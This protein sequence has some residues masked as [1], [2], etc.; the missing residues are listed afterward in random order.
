MKSRLKQGQIKWRYWIQKPSNVGYF[1]L[2][3]TIVILLAISLFPLIYAI[4]VSL[5][6]YIISK[7]YLGKP[8]VGLGNYVRLFTDKD[9]YYSLRVTFL[10]ALPAIAGEYFLGLCCALLLNR[11]I[12]GMGVIRTI[13]VM[14]MMIAPVVV[15][16]MW[17]F[18]FDFDTGILNYF[19]RQ[20][21][22]H[23]PNWL[24][25]KNWAI[26]AII[27]TD[28]WQWT[29]LFTLLILAG[30]QSLPSEPFEAAKVDGASSWQIFTK[31][32]FPMLMPFMLIAL[33]LR[34]ID[35]FRVFDKVFVMTGGGPGRVTVFISLFAYRQAF[36]FYYVSYGI[37]VA[38]IILIIITLFA[39]LFINLFKRAE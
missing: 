11:R 39:N 6:Q 32:T 38:F 22:I 26:P 10:F 20:L 29:P 30:L 16:L 15:G 13:I 2:A 21:G 8:W 12:R 34:V 9:F 25:D 1:F 33:L 23:P 37:A 24:G 36:S 31:I 18:M 19:L 5:H 35:V 17:K 4:N 7:P 14:P 3:P 27:I 28:I